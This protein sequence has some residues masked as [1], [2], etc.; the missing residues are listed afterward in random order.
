MCPPGCKI[1]APGPEI[2]PSTFELSKF[3]LSKFEHSKFEL[4]KFDPT[5]DLYKG[6]ARGP[7]RGGGAC[8]EQ[9]A[10]DEWMASGEQMACDQWVACAE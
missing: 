10:C 3:E 7:L 2:E 6:T 9:V 5:G 8:D 4:S 1:G